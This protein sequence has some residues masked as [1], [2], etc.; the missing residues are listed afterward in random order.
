MDECG[1]SGGRFSAETF[2]YTAISIRFITSLIKIKCK[3]GLAFINIFLPEIKINIKSPA[4][5]W[6][7]LD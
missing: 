5:S 2:M 3:N 4:A 7:E 1:Q 6:H